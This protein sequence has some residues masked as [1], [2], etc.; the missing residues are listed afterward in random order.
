M[1]FRMIF[2]VVSYMDP[3]DGTSK[4]PTAN[5]TIRIVLVFFIMAYSI[6]GLGVGIL[7]SKPL[8]RDRK[9]LRMLEEGYEEFEG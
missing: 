7:L 2:V 3:Y 4:V 5:S 9:S 6:L 8:A 1:G